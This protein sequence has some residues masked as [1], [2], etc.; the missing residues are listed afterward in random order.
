MK[1]KAFLLI[2]CFIAI[3]HSSIGQ[4]K[5]IIL[6]IHQPNIQECITIIEDNF[7]LADI[8]VYPNPNKGFFTLE[9]TNNQFRG[10]ARI[11][12]YN[13]T[14]KLI[15]NEQFT[16]NFSEFRKQI[17]LSNHRNGLYILNITGKKGRYE[18]EIMIF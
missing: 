5:Y 16:L 15:F 2:I 13:S 8:I 7:K 1:I 9:I 14:G 6:S 17:D 10:K 4:I 12:I 18:C 11:T 3:S